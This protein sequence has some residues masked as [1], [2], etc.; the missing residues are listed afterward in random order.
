MSKYSEKEL[1]EIFRRLAKFYIEGYP[2]DKESIERFLRWSHHQ[3][4][5]T[6]E[7]QRSKSDVHL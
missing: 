1:F 5:Y 6:Y 2:Q 3:Y 4:G 7:Q